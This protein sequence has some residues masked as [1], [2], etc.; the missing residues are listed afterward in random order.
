[1][2][3]QQVEKTIKFYETLLNEFPTPES[4]AVNILEA[5]KLLTTGIAQ[6]NFY[7]YLF[8]PSDYLFQE[9][10]KT[11][12][13]KDEDEYNRLAEEFDKKNTLEVKHYRNGDD[14]NIVYLPNKP[15]AEKSK[16]LAST[17]PTVSSEAQITLHEGRDEASRK[18]VHQEIEDEKVDN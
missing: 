2:A 6:T 12:S 15:N 14:V 9:D 8:A 16:S 4:W 17:S 5:S 13:Q 11:I 3:E 18:I 10:V 1:M 7:R